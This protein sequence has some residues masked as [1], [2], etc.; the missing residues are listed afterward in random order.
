MVHFLVWT[1]DWT[2]GF[3][4]GSPLLVSTADCDWTFV[5]VRERESAKHLKVGDLYTNNPIH[6]Y[7]YFFNLFLR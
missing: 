7:S 1:A 6:I 4:R 2:L 3:V 5:F